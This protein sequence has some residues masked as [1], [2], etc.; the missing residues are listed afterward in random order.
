[1]I[2]A[3]S[4]FA[5]TAGGSGFLSPQGVGNYL[6]AAARAGVIAAPV[7]LLMTAGEFDL[8]IGSMVGLSEILIAYAV[9]R[10]HWP[11]AAALA[12]VVAIAALIGFVNAYVLVK[13]G[14]PSFIV[15]LA[16]LFVLLGLAEGLSLVLVGSSIISNITEPLSGDPLLPVFHGA[17]LGVLTPALFWWLGA[18]L[19]AA[20]ILHG[21]RFGNWIYATGGN[22]DS[23][24]KS[25]VPV[26]R[27]KTILYMATAISSAI[28]GC[29]FAF[30]VNTANAD[31]GSNLVFQVVTIVVI[32]GTLITGGRGSPIGAAIAALLFGVI[33]QGFFF[34]D[35]PQGWYNLFLGAMLMFAVLINKYSGDV[36]ESGTAKFLRRR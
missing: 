9:V 7:C 27:V 15:T 6:E 14:L 31:D 16:A 1:L 4:Y 24:A 10:L 19:I 36:A 23:A 11:L 33:S 30:Q 28:A 3:F 5:V 25:G 8:S 29:L 35:I 21:T 17:G 26:L 32:G 22:V 13:T 20:W 18:T 2:V 34:T 12:G